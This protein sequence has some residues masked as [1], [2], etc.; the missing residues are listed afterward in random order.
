MKFVNHY[1]NMEDV[2]TLY[3]IV[4][5]A[6]LKIP[7]KE[8]EDFRKSV[9][10]G[11]PLVISDY[12]Q[13]VDQF[14]EVSRLYQ[15]EHWEFNPD[16]YLGGEESGY[17]NVKRH[18]TKFRPTLTDSGLCSSFN[19]EVENNMFQDQRVEEF[20]EVFHSGWETENRTLESADLKEISFII[21]TQDRRNYPF[22]ATGGSRNLARLVIFLKQVKYEWV[23]FLNETLYINLTLMGLKGLK[24]MINEFQVVLRGPKGS[25]GVLSPKGAKWDMKV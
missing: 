11:Q 12:L 3:N 7:V 2:S 24:R 17:A 19:T 13:Y 1:A 15:D 20:M 9:F 8:Y 10:L 16:M 18:S 25:Q 22:V 5:D 6:G 21:D 14:S 4:K 23:S